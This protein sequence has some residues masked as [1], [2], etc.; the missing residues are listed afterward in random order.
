MQG[1]WTPKPLVLG[2]SVVR[3]PLVRRQVIE[4]GLEAVGAF[5][6]PD[7]QGGRNPNRRSAVEDGDGRLT[8]GTRKL[9]AGTLAVTV[10]QAHGLGGGHGGLPQVHPYVPFVPVMNHQISRM[11][12]SAM[13]TA[14]TIAD[15]ERPLLPFADS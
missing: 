4:P 5:V 11:M 8:F 2:R 1:V 10:N 13:M 9:K 12:M 3:Y 7:H 6:F 15:V 14:V